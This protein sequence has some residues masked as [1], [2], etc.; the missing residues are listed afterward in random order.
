M[1]DCSVAGIT[2]TYGNKMLFFL[3]IFY[4]FA[5]AVVPSQLDWFR[6]ER[7]M[8][9][10]TV[11]FRDAKL[12]LAVAIASLV[13]SSPAQAQQEDRFSVSSW[14]GASSIHNGGFGAALG[15]VPTG[16]WSRSGL[17]LQ[18]FVHRGTFRYR[19]EDR[20]I[21]DAGYTEFALLGGYAVIA[22]DHGFTVSAGP[23][24]NTRDR[25]QGFRTVYEDTR[26]GL[27][28]T[29]SGYLAPS[30][31]PSAFGYASHSTADGTGTIYGNLG[32]KVRGYTVGPE[33]ALVEASNFRQT[34]LGVHVS[35]LRVGQ[36]V[37]GISAG[38]T[39]DQIGTNGAHVGMNLRSSF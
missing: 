36:V 19:S 21:V 16:T 13:A 26:N 22:P 32:Y 11:Y 14:V 27:R 1:C 20:G 33:A 39:R 28:F 31:G 37:F 38:L 10:G 30:T 25:T 9:M 6:A 7:R 35:E 3:P 12:L 18:A 8:V 23:S 2:L 5:V 24:I 4:H 15:Y 17:R 29:A 34:R